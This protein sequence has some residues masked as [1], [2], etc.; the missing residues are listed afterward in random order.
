MSYSPEDFFYD[1]PPRIMG[2]ET[3][4]NVDYLSKKCNFMPF[5]AEDEYFRES[6]RDDGNE[7]WLENGAR[8]YLDSGG[9][10]EYATPETDSARSVVAYE[11]AGEHIVQD[12]ADKMKGEP[13]P[14]YKRSGY[15]NVS[16]DGDVFLERMTAGHH[17]NYATPLYSFEHQGVEDHPVDR[18]L[19]SYLAT[20]A[21]WA[22][23]GIVSNSGFALS[24]KLRSI[25][26]TQHTKRAGAFSMPK[27]AYIIESNKDFNRLE[28]RLGDGNMSEWA[29]QQKF[30][31]TSLM[32]RLIEHGSFPEELYIENSVNHAFT[33]T[34]RNG[35][36]DTKSGRMTAATH[37]R[38]LAEAALGFAASHSEVPTEEVE[39]AHEV[40]DACY[41]I[42]SLDRDLEGASMLS[43]RVDW[44]AKITYMRSQG[45]SD[46]T[47]KNIRAVAFDLRWED[48]KSTGIARRWYEQFYADRAVS[49]AEIAQARMV[50]P[51]TRALARTAY[52]S[53]LAGHHPS[54]IHW[55]RV[56]H[57]GKFQRFDNLYQTNF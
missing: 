47:T 25:D 30:A 5:F 40:I 51:A 1:T 7:L 38:H 39:A 15:D 13:N 16:L 23:A 11:K 44:A 9:V 22:G 37:Q 57:K 35:G 34:L 19:K 41:D 48:I 17:E 28:I 54:S 14:T 3:E 36:V 32:L 4:Y 43:D 20:R 29:I 2:S 8:F 49:E 55:H 53:S 46:F 52:L 27:A 56:D 42:D 21:I 50:P 6:S 33:T 18:S 12:L 31:L 24:Q 10:V 26:F 45:V